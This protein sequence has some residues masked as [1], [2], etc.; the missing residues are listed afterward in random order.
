VLLGCLPLSGMAQSASEQ[1][2]QNPTEG[3]Q[4][5]A[6]SGVNTGAPSAPVLDAEH[7]PITAG[8]F[9]K[10]GPVVFEDITVS[11]GLS[12]WS[13]RM[14]TPEK[15]Y[16]LETVGSGVALLDYDNDG[17]LDIYLVNGSTYDAMSGTQTPPHA[18]LFHNNHDGTFTDVTQQAGVGND[19]WGFGA[20]VADY[21]ND[22]W[23]DIYVS[24]FGKNRLYHNNHDGTFTD[25]AEKAGVALG[26]W[27]TGATWGDYDGDGRLDLFVP[28]YIHYDLTNP[29]SQGSKSAAYRFCEFRGVRV[30]C[31]PR[32]LKGEADHLFR[33][34]GDGTFTDTSVAAGVSDAKSTNY[35]LASL[36]IDMNNDGKVDLLVADDSTPNYLYLNKGN[37]TF[38]DESF[39]SGYAF[40]DSG[41]ETA[42]MGIAAGDI[43]H[44]GLIDIFNTTFSDDYKPL[45]RNDGD[46]NLTDISYQMGIAEPTVPFL[47]WGTGFFDYDNDGWLDLFE[48][49]G[50][51]Y[52]QVDR[53]NWGTSWKQRP[54]L[55]HNVNGKLEL[56]PAVE[57]TGLAT[58]GVGRGMAFGDLFNDGKI[59]VVI[60]NLDGPPTLLR[61]VVKNQNH[62]IELRLV[63]GATS[64]RDA[65]GATVYVTANGF[66]QRGDVVSGGSYASSSDPRLH[67]GLGLV[68]TIQSVEVHWPNGPVER[69]TLPG[70]DAIYTVVEGGGT[71]NAWAPVSAKDATRNAPSSAAGAVD[72]AR[73]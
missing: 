25:V 48:A 59:D 1:Q 65:I 64:P 2:V 50:H 20:A 43:T 3:A 9:V 6:M 7:R 62:W 54:L 70:V 5:A 44:N 31:G 15:P 34:N 72:G 49:N 4:S 41:R 67:F 66:R 57:G 71:G 51:V 8:G 53:M 23:P 36:F 21:D 19:R 12:K 69:I 11:S 45:Y 35:G 24:N 17:W 61:N 63:G 30:M 10:S 38:D 52:P 56:V 16:I 32:G 33:N 68:T 46:A 40:N 13:N 39:S 60:N 29:P 55:F 28:G 37:G 27:S 22:G 18:A 47:G 42:S 14:G 26:N 73:R 58:L